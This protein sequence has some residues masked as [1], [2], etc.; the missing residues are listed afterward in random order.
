MAGGI[1]LVHCC[2]PST[3]LG[4]W[5][6][7][8]TWLLGKGRNGRRSSSVAETGLP[9]MG[10][11]EGDVTVLGISKQAGFGF[12]ALDLETILVCW[13]C[14]DHG[15]DLFKGRILVVTFP[16]PSWKP[17]SPVSQPDGPVMNHPAG[18]SLPSRVDLS[19][20]PC[21]LSKSQAGAVSKGCV[22]PETLRGGRQRTWIG[23][24][25]KCQVCLCWKGSRRWSIDF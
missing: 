19:L 8:N 3:V 17:P 11:G 13:G 14:D 20:L 21:Q 16:L 6:I 2:Y 7:L 22:F 24:T 10:S 25:L 18:N 4:L 1:C 12:L 9:E 23:D 5:L 15:V